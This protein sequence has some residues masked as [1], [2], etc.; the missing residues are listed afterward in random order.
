MPYDIRD[1][2][3]WSVFSGACGHTY[4]NHCV[5]QFYDE[6]RKPV[7]FAN[8][9]WKKAVNAQGAEQM[10]YLKL[11]MESR[12]FIDA[13]PD[14]SLIS[15]KNTSGAEHIQVLK[16]KSFAFIYIPTGN[17]PPVKL[18]KISGKQIKAWWFNPRTGES[19]NIGEFENSG[20]KIFTVPGMSKELDWLRS[21]RGCDWVIVLDDAS[22]NFREPGK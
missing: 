20:E 21:G 8:H 6:I 22:K 7:T 3:Y 16:G 17:V 5:W 12:P 1:I 2:A 11:L 15:G 13:M 18:G 10:K 19:T 9:N 4:G 14:N